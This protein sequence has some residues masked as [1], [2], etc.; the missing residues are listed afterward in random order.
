MGSNVTKFLE[1]W[2]L[3]FSNSFTKNN[4]RV[5]KVNTNLKEILLYDF[6]I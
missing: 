4:T 1:C 5:I 3:Y 6:S 2:D